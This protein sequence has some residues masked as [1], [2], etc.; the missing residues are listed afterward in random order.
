MGRL[1][2][3][4]PGE[5][6]VAAYSFKRLQARILGGG[7]QPIFEFN[8]GDVAA[9]SHVNYRSRMFISTRF[10]VAEL[11][12]TEM[13]FVA[14]KLAHE[15]FARERGTVR[16]RRIEI[17]DTGRKHVSAWRVNAAIKV[18]LQLEQHVLL[19]IVDQRNKTFDENF[20]SLNDLADSAV[21][22]PLYSIPTGPGVCVPHAFIKDDGEMFRSIGMTYRLIA[23]PDITVFI[24]DSSASVYEASYREENASPKNVID[25]EWAQMVGATT[26]M[27]PLIQK[28]PVHLAGRRGMASFV[29]FTRDDKS[30]DFG[31]MAVVRGDP[32]AADDRPDVYMH[33]LRDQR[34]ALAKGIEPLDEKA[35]LKF[36]ES[37]AAS[38]RHR[39]VK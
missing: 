5:A 15:K 3:D 17:V 25:S 32:D 33:V 10:S 28:R 1:Q 34:K 39:P 35:F 31:Y 7:G 13:N 18:M 14:S 6:E 12:K 30:T 21:Y 27:W 8:D 24:E 36:A 19:T 16:L 29:S 9:R 26:P 37:I 4:L 23:H 2:L 38:L 22:R 20:K 11:R